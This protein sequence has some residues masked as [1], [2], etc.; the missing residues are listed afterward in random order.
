MN[1]AMIPAMPRLIH[2]LYC[3]IEFSLEPLTRNQ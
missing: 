3:L 1:L 2:T